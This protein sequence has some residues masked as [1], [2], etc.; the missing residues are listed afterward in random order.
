MF[1][2]VSMLC[3]FPFLASG[4]KE[5]FIK[6]FISYKH[7][8]RVSILYCDEGV[9]QSLRKKPVNIQIVHQS[10]SYKLGFIYRL[11]PEVNGVS[12]GITSL[13]PFTVPV[14]FAVIVVICLSLAASQLMGG[15]ENN[16][17]PSSHNHFLIDMIGL[18]AQQG[19]TESSSRVP[20]RIALY[21]VMVMTFLLYNYYSASIV[22]ELLSG[23]N[24]GPRTIEELAE[25]PL[26]VVF[27]N[28]SYNR[29]LLEAST[30]SEGTTSVPVYAD[31]ATAVRLLKQGGFA[32]HCEPTE[33]FRE[34]AEQ[35][36]ADEICELRTMQ[37]LYT[38]LR[39]MSFVLPKGSMYAEQFRITLTR[40]NEM[41][42][43]RR[44]L[45]M[46][47]NEMPECQNGPLMQPV[48]MAGVATPF[49]ILGGNE[50]NLGED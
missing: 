4:W 16:Y 47:R 38:K 46:Y 6:D 27:N 41:G 40:A 33:A 7:S 34:L 50:E 43:I 31:V 8:R 35:L 28:D 17:S 42:L 5:E 23:I 44:L 9:L 39:M 48:V 37:G 19:T 21:A 18:I 11:T 3:F 36:D 32:F 30:I 1:S 20:V 26:K 25:C 12:R 14:W 13:S 49:T 45:G 15:C 22:G 2:L 24:P 29:N 10:W